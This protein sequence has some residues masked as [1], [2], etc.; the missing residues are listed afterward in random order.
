MSRETN[1]KLLAQ[2][3]N[4]ILLP[5]IKWTAGGALDV[6]HTYGGEGPITYQ[7]QMDAVDGSVF[8]VPFT[9]HGL[10]RF[11]D[12]LSVLLAYAKEH[13]DDAPPPKKAH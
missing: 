4:P 1:E 11:V 10:E 7:I 6:P 3:T 2:L 12:T 5:A 13:E 9:R 8:Q